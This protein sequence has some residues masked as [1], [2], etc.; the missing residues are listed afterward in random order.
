MSQWVLLHTGQ[1][2]LNPAT[3]VEGG[4]PFCTASHGLA[5]AWPHTG[6][7]VPPC[8][9]G[10]WAKPSPDY[11]EGWDGGIPPLHWCQGLG[12]PP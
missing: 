5:L 10:S 11:T 8:P 7:T 2:P 9:G 4:F 6:R 3:A 1:G 12:N